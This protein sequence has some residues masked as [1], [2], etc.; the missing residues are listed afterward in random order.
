[1]RSIIKRLLSITIASLGL[2]LS[3]A[4]IAQQYP[5][6]T[7]TIIVP[8]SAGGGMD[9][10]ARLLAENIK[11]TLGQTVIVDNNDPYSLKDVT[12]SAIQDSS[13]PSVQPDNVRPPKGVPV[14]PNTYP[15]TSPGP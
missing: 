8:F 12:I 4:A 2:G 14:G 13:Q 5:A 7:I 11:N 3:L 9:T 6:K 15:N 10:V 1:M